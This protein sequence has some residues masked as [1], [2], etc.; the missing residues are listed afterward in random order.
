MIVCLGT[1]P[2]VQRVMVFNRVE[3]N[4]VNRAAETI[5][6]A[7]GKSINVAK[8]VTALGERAVA[9]GFVGG[10]R[11]DFLCAELDRLRVTHDFV[12]VTARTRECITIIDRGARTHTELVEESRAVESAAWEAVDAKLDRLLTGARML[13]ASGTLAP[14]APHDFY[15]RCVRQAQERGVPTILDAAGAALMESLAARPL[16]V[17]PNRAELEKTFGMSLES[18]AALGDAMGSLMNAGAHSVVITAGSQGAF[19]MDERCRFRVRSP[20]VEAL[21]S[22][23]SGDAFT[24]GLAVALAAGQSLRDACK[25]GTACGAANALT[26]MAGDVRISDVRRLTNEA[27]VENW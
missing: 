13:V 16:V 23:G 21:N 22:I 5:D 19:A 7:A 24:A 2:A 6:G 27:V 25:L 15:A 1:T 4:G 9:T 11:G 26:L 20:K 8:V 17:K 3:I 14:Q 10:D 12:R 18:D